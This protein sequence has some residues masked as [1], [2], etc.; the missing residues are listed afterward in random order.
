M[1]NI[2]AQSVVDLLPD[3]PVVLLI[4]SVAN[5]YRG[6][7]LFEEYP[8][9][10]GQS[11]IENFLVLKNSIYMLH[12]MCKGC[13]K[14]WKRSSYSEQADLLDAIA[15]QLKSVKMSLQAES[16]TPENHF[17]LPKWL[18]STCHRQF[19]FF[20]GAIRHDQTGCHMMTDAINYTLRKPLGVVALITPWNLP[21]YLLS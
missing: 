12:L 7:R 6:Q 3:S 20:A 17:T 18:I 15:N 1:S 21:L 9:S 4:G 2:I 10:D 11:S 14:E 5:R 8:S 13:T 16:L 19:R